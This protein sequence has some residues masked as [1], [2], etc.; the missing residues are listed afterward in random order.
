MGG[1]GSAQAAVAGAVIEIAADVACGDAEGAAKRGHGMGEILTDTGALA[2]DIACM[3]GCCGGAGCV[4]VIA[5]DVIHDGVAGLKNIFGFA[6]DIDCLTPD[7]GC[8]FY[9]G[10]VL[11]VGVAFFGNRACF[12]FAVGVTVG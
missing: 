5:V 1:F 6:F 10:A 11:Q 7:F 3:G 8:V 12:E 9:I 4:L 2:N